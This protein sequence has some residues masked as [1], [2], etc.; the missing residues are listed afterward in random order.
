[1]R[2][3]FVSAIVACALLVACGEPASSA[4]SVDGSGGSGGSGGAAGARPADIAG[5][6]APAPDDAGTPAAAG[7]GGTAGAGG[8]GGAAS[9]GGTGGAGAAPDAGT[10][11]PPSTS[12]VY[13]SGYGPDITHFTLD[14]AT[15]ALTL[16]EAIAAGSSPSYLAI[17]PSKRALYAVNEGSG[18]DS[19]VLAFAIDADSGALTAINSAPS[20]GE[21]AP[22]LAVH[23]SG[24]YV[25]VAHYGSGH[26]TILP[27]G[28]DDGVSDPI[29]SERGPS[30]GC[31][32]AHQAV[33]D[34]SG[35][36]LLVP[37]L[38]S[39]YV[40]QLVFSDG[41]L[42]YASP[43]T[44]PVSGGPRHLALAPDEHHAYVLSELEST[45]TSFVYDAASGTLS[46][47]QTIDSQEQTKGASA[48]I[49]VHP[50]G[51]FLYASN[52]S[53]NSLGLFAIDASG[54]PAPVAFEHD[55]IDTP[56]DFTID[57][58]GTYLLLANQEGAQ[59]LR[60]YRIAQADGRLTH[61]QTAAVGGSPTF[62]GSVLL[63]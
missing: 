16:R 57:P 29:A 38:D 25:A 28:A 17:A 61:V 59:D 31:I 45:L 35:Q 30:D 58:T 19:R 40:L 49:V 55:G 32:K 26:T 52:R 36:H 24:T 63:P 27:I 56:R 9:A 62:V 47:P 46:D 37:C 13:V 15:G 33:F 8:A 43:A 20:G 7:A 39:S 50:S 4:E 2:A 54:R 48:H 14:L 34:A 51:R 3:H 42:S 18:A 21:G 60:V 22:H 6:S 11:E 53:E 44:A 23:P 12:H 1:M 5:T 10:V 41:A